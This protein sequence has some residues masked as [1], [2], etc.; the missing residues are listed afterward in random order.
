M[1]LV[2]LG[3]PKVGHVF[4]FKI[5]IPQFLKRVGFATIQFVQK[6]LKVLKRVGFATIQFIQKWLKVLKRVGFA[7]IQFI[8]K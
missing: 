8:Q 7:T 3:N 2:F 6:W 1:S 4:N 5:I